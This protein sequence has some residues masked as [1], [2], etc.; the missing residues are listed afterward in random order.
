VGL[1]RVALLPYNPATTAKYK[2][3][4]LPYELVGQSQSGERLA[5]VASM[6]QET[7]HES[8]IG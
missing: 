3:L 2:W 1:T 6:A 4:D 5:E 7:G 8:T